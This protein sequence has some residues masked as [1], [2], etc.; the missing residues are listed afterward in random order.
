[1]RILAASVLAIAAV[2]AGSGTAFAADD[3]HYTCSA[4]D[5][6]NVANCVLVQDIHNLVQDVNLLSHDERGPA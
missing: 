4:P 3:R 5:S 1:M 2:F 6:V